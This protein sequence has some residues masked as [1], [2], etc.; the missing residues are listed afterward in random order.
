MR[1][2]RLYMAVK[3]SEGADVALTF[4]AKI[5]P[6]GNTGSELTDT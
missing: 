1:T 4:Q 3:V 2:D 6:H 5:Q